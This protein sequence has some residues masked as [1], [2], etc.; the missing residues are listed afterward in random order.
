MDR[1]KFLEKVSQKSDAAIGD[2]EEVLQKFLELVT[3]KLRDG[4]K[5]HLDKFGTFAPRISKATKKFSALLNREIEIPERF[6]VSFIPSKRLADDINFTYRSEQPKILQKGS[7]RIIEKKVEIMSTQNNDTE[8]ELNQEERIS[9]EEKTSDEEKILKE[10]EERISK[11]EREEGELQSEIEHEELTSDELELRDELLS[12]LSIEEKG[13]QSKEGVEVESKTPKETQE[14]EEASTMPEMNLNQGK[15]FVYA[16]EDSAAY[17]SGSYSPR[18]T[19]ES[20]QESAPQNYSKKE[21]SPALWITLVILLLGIIGLGIYWALSVDVTKTKT[22]KQQ[23]I[24]E[25]SIEETPPVIVEKK[26]IPGDKKQI[27]IAPE[28]FAGETNEIQLKEKMNLLKE[29][30]TPLTEKKQDAK[31]LTVQLPITTENKERVK[32]IQRRTITTKAKSEKLT[33]ASSSGNIFIQVNSY[34]EERFAKAAALELKNKGYRSF[35][36]SADVPGIGRVYRVRVGYYNDDDAAAKDY[37]A[38]RLLLKN[39]KIYVDRR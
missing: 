11:I 27:I 36:E 39:D 3:F 28:E 15:K 35:I 30:P 26:P 25:K 37:H 33:K 23:P 16:E 20:T 34:R 9:A 18:Q 1:D 31:Q 12:F 14:K 21:S 29:E 24:V 2:I 32:P 10:L 22:E 6:K 7:E 4:E 13:E 5:I 38:L 17:S 8:K 19:K